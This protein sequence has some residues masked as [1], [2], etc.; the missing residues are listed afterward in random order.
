MAWQTEGGA[1]THR[2]TPG[3]QCQADRSERREETPLMPQMGSQGATPVR[4]LVTL[5]S[6]PGTWMDGW[7]VE[8]RN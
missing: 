8:E 1:L 7:M 4:L 6:Q 2:G 3:R 5:H